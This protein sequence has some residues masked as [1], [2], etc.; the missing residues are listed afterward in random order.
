[1]DNDNN[2][3]EFGY[4]YEIKM[5]FKEKD[6]IVLDE[7]FTVSYIN[8]SDMYPIWNRRDKWD[9][10]LPKGLAIRCEKIFRMNR[11]GNMYSG[12]VTDDSIDFKPLVKYNRGIESELISK[13]FKL[14]MCDMNGMKYTTYKTPE[15]LLRV[16]K[17]N[18]ILFVH[19]HYY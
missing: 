10:I 7:D 13:R 8:S 17:I 2:V 11:V 1:M 18:K 14:D 9:Y 3:K 19:L 16:R 5:D 4:V 15:A 6:W 12:A